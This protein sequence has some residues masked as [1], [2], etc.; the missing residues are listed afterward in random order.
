M[1]LSYYPF[2]QIPSLTF[3]SS[4]FNPLITLER[5]ACAFSATVG[6]YS[7]S[8]SG[9]GSTPLSR[10]SM[11]SNAFCIRITTSEYVDT[12]FSNLFRSSIV[13]VSLFLSSTSSMLF[14]SMSKADYNDR[15]Y[16]QYIPDLSHNYPYSQSGY[17][18]T[19]SRSFSE[20]AKTCN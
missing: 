19:D 2:I 9:S 3:F 20:A 16:L 7:G 14:C 4:R 18:R 8:G 1:A 12:Y 5:R 13:S 11:S 6:T 17:D 10:F 15:G